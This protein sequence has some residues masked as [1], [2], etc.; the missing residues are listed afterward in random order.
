[1]SVDPRVEKLTIVEIEPLVPRTVSTFFSA[2]NFDVVR[3]PKTHV[4]IDDARHFVQ[5]SREKYDAITSDPL[6]PW[7]K[8]AAMLYSKEF[9]ESARQHLNPGGAITLFVQLYWSNEEAVKSELATFFE[10]FPNGIVW[11]NT[12]DGGGYDLVLLGQVDPAPINID[13]MEERLHRP[14]FATIAQSLASIGF[15]SAM[16]LLATYAGQG[17]DMAPWLRDAAINRDRNLRLQYLAGMGVN[18]SQ[19]Q[20][21]YSAM[22]AYRRPPENV[23]AG[24]DASKAYLWEA[25]QGSKTP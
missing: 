5:T 11:G 19:S 24:S 21:I 6:D 15:R 20:A 22:L 17:R 1:V 4:Y 23:F 9:F 10:A 18:A 25:I 13:E 7:V 16:D 14:E 12:Y 3:N 8:G 2:Y